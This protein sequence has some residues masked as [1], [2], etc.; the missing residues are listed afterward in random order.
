MSMS[1]SPDMSETDWVVSVCPVCLSHGFRRI[2]LKGKLP[3]VKC[4]NCE[5]QIQQP[6]PS[7]ARLNKIYGPN[8]FISFPDNANLQNH[9]GKLKNGT[10]RLQ[11][12]DLRA[13]A[14][15]K[16]QRDV[17][18]MRLL[19]IGPGHGYMLQEAKRYGFDITGLEYSVHATETANKNLSGDYVRTGMLETSAAS[20]GTFDVIVL[21]DLIEHVRDPRRFLF[22]AFEILKPGGMISIA[23]ISTESLTARLL[24]RYWMEYKPEHLFYFNESNIVTLLKAVGFE[25]TKVTSGCKVMSWSY[26]AAHFDIFHVPVLTPLMSLSLRIIPTNIAR[27]RFKTVP[28]G[29]NVVARRPPPT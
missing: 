18:G 3:L 22:Q 6:Q 13:Y 9:V 4:D 19:E 5:L 2:H 29:F 10:A 17:T 1:E 28:S 12:D 20:L 15:S 11:L 24:G 16:Q 21:S 8:Y 27:M 7:D 23:T 14:A 25:E 26:I